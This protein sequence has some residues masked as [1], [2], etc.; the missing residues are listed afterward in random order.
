MTIDFPPCFDKDIAG[1]NQQS[2]N[3][4]RWPKQLTSVGNRTIYPL[5]GSAMI[6]QKKGGK[7]H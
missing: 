7:S 4:F 2:W 6:F 3:I 5:L 1:F